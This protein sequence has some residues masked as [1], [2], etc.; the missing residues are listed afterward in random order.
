METVARQMNWKSVL[1]LFISL[2][3]LIGCSTEFEKYTYTNYKELKS[4]E[5]EVNLHSRV[6]INGDETNRAGDFVIVRDHLL[7]IDYQADEFIKIFDLKSHKLL[8]SFGRH[9][10]GPSEFIQPVQ[11]ILSPKDKNV[12]WIFDLST[13]QLKKYD[14]NN[15]LNNEF[16][17]E[18]IIRLKGENGFNIHFVITP[19]D[20]ILVTGF[21]VNGRINIFNM[22]GDLIKTIGK[23]PIKIKN[24]LLATSHSHGFIGN[25]IYKTKTGE[26]FIATKNGSII[27]EYSNVGEL[28]STFHGPDTF[29]P[30][31]DIVPTGNNYYSMCFNKKTRFGYL[32]ICYCE[33][34]DRLFLLYSG[35]FFREG[36]TAFGGKIVYVLNDDEEIIEQLILDKG[37]YRIRVSEDGSTLFGETMGNEIVAYEYDQCTDI[38]LKK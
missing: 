7:L 22:D 38:G 5:K 9:G 18:R 29:F 34:T 35:K 32:D 15:V 2:L 27:E 12:F 33:K 14:I 8:K 6:I 24:K 13:K 37:V 36:K 3:M 23:I 30:E 21:Y 17:P 20:K 31:Y 1:V 26:I 19:D 28:L 4:P 11:I 25:F 16:R 10:Q